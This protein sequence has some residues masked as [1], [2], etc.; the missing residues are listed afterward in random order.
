LVQHKTDIHTS[1]PKEV[2][3][4]EQ[5]HSK[6]HKHHKIEHKHP[7]EEQNV[8]TK[9]TILYPVYGQMS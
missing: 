8:Q 4:L 5:K 7:K 1:I 6:S 3:A 2:I 9:D